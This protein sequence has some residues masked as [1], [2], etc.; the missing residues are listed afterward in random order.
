MID[1]QNEEEDDD[2]HRIDAIHGTT[3]W[4]GRNREEFWIAMEEPPQDFSVL[5]F[6]IFT[7]RVP[8]G[9]KS[10][11]TISLFNHSLCAY[12]GPVPQIDRA[13]KQSYAYA[14]QIWLFS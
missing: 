14:L 6:D 8:N 5:S 13:L 2:K 3:I 12:Q 9:A 7:R 10:Q 1:D 4:R 11:C